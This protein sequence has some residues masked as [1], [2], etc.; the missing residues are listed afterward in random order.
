MSEG[1]TD[2]MVLQSAAGWYIGTL[3]QEDDGYYSPGSRDSIYFK[4]KEE[5]EKVLQR[6][7]HEKAKK[8]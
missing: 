7:R 8:I 2:L 1:Y 3:Y 6:R 5:A 4:T